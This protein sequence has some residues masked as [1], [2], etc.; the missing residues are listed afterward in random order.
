MLTTPFVL[1]HADGD[2]SLNRINN[3]NYASEYLAKRSTDEIRLRVRHTKTKA[4]STGGVSKDR[5]NVEVT[6]TTYATAEAA[7]DVQKFYFVWEHAPSNQD[8]KLVD[9]L[10]DKV[11]A[12]ANG[13]LTELLGW[14]S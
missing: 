8:L 4:S 9:A 13:F 14:N 5:H 1:P 11:I 10:C 6:Q 12:S 2:I 7:E 3:D